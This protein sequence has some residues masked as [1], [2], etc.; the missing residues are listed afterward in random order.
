MSSKPET[1]EK[2]DK[3]AME[4]HENI[5]NYSAKELADFLRNYFPHVIM[6]EKPGSDLGFIYAFR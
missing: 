4:Y 2:I 6:K 1:L 5:A 3:L